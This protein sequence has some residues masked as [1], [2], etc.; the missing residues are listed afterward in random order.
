MPTCCIKNCTSRTDGIYKKNIKFFRFPK[1]TDIS[2]RWLQVCQRNEINTKIDSA[3]ICE[4][5]FEA[6]CFEMKWT[7]P[8]SSNVPAKQLKR[9]KKGS[10]PSKMLIIEKTRKRTYT[11]IIKTDNMEQLNDENIN[12]IADHENVSVK[13][14]LNLLT[15]IEEEKKKLSIEINQLIKRNQELV[16]KNIQLCQQVEQLQTSVEEKSRIIRE[17]II[18]HRQKEAEKI[19][20]EFLRKIFTSGQI[21][22]V[23]SLNNKRIKWSSEDIIS[24]IGL[25]SLSPKAYRYLREVKNIPL[26]CMTTLQNWCAAFN[27]PPGILKNTLKERNKKYMV[28]IKHV[29]L[30]WH[31]DYLKNGNNYILR[32]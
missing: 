25:R 30:L 6:D 3:F 1:E 23:I 9:L 11:Q 7:K 32:F 16:E 15:K 12:K 10:I 29:S 20:T 8:H 28:L 19:A 26:P 17:T 5:H 21:K 4:L 13:T 2:Q 27:V 22:K 31:E 14:L 18:V 24:A